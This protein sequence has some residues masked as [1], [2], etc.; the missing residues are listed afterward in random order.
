MSLFS[1][2]YMSLQGFIIIITIIVVV[3]LLL[4]SSLELLGQVK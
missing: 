3:V 4:I 2:H 1:F